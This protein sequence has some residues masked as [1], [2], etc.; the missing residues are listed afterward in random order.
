MGGVGGD[1]WGPQIDFRYP[2]IDFRYLEIDFLDPKIDLGDH[3]MVFDLQRG[4]AE[5]RF[6]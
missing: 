1:T 3:K 4:K 5:N 2:E 6:F